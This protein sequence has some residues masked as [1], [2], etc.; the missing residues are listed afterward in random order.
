MLGKLV[1]HVFAFAFGVFN[2]VVMVGIAALRDGAFAKRESDN[3]KK[4][5]ASGVLRLSSS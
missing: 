4:E 1:W 5:L 2:L 3:K